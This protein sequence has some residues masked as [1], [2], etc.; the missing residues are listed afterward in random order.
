M[1]SSF[2]IRKSRNVFNGKYLLDETITMQILQL[3]LGKLVKTS[4]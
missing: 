2:H 4:A 3:Q 1:Y